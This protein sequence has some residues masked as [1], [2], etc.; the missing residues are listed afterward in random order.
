MFPSVNNFVKSLESFITAPSKTFCPVE[1]NDNV[2]MQ[3]TNIF[4]EKTIPVIC[5]VMYERERKIYQKHVAVER[6]T[7]CTSRRP[8][9]WMLDL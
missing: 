6:T 3:R 8:S 9:S 4:S 1:I 2:D 5:V 7:L